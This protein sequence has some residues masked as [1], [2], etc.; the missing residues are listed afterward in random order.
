MLIELITAPA[1]RMPYQTG[2]N[3]SQLGS[4]TLTDSPGSTPRAI[5]PLA[6]RLERALTSPYEIQSPSANLR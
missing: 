4:I 5:R 6:T 3:S 2:R 1:L